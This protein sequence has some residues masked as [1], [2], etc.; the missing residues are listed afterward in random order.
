M[1]GAGFRLVNYFR[2]NITFE[3]TR[4]T[5]TLIFGIILRAAQ[6]NVSCNS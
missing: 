6:F 1:F 5:S 4:L 2:S 3:R